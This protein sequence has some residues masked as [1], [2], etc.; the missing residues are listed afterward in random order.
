VAGVRAAVYGSRLVEVLSPVT[1]V[2]GGGRRAGGRTGRWC[3]RVEEGIEFEHAVFRS[4]LIVGGRRSAVGVRALA[5]RP[6]PTASRV[7]SPSGGWPVIAW[8]AFGWRRAG[9]KPGAGLGAA[10]DLLAAWETCPAII[11]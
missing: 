4:V 8:G 5:A 9:W 3:E 1:P 7:G 11:V 6:S 2:V 10:S